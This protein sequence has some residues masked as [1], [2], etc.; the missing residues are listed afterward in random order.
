MVCDPGEA[1]PETPANSSPSGS[2]MGLGS[3]VA[4]TTRS[5]TTT[6]CGALIASGAVTCTCLVYEPGLSPV[7]ST[8]SV[9]RE[10]GAPPGSL[11]PALGLGGASQAGP[12]A[13]R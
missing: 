7:G 5:V 3:S 11:E 1:L 6:V 12:G 8:D 4:A 10:V 9:T 2:A 13:L